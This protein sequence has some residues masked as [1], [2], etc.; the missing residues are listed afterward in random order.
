MAPSSTI[1]MVK[2]RGGPVGT[3][4]RKEKCIEV[5]KSHQFSSITTNVR[6]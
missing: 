4:K 1:V 6:K 5:V 3:K 2:F